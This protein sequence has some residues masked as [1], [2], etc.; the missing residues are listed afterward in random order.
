MA[1]FMM[2][3]NEATALLLDREADLRKRD[4]DGQ[5]ALIWAAQ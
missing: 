5:T 4:W 3:R 1:A 2:G